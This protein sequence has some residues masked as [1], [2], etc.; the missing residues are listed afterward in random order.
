MYHQ[1]PKRSKKIHKIPK[2]TNIPKISTTYPKDPKRSKTNYSS[3]GSCSCSSIVKNSKKINKMPKS[4]T[5]Y[6]KDPK[7]SKRYPKVSPL[8]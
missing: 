6:P 4:T 2:R 1:I 5:T 8:T 7:R 3:S